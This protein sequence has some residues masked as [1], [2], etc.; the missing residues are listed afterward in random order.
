MISLAGDTINL[1]E[2]GPVVMEKLIYFMY[3]GTV[4]VIG[5]DPGMIVTLLSAAQHYQ[6]I[7]LDTG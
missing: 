4:D 3:T 6:E 5:M 7:I 2:F 1:P